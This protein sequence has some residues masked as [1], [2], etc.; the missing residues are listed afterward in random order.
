[1]LGGAGIG[2]ALAALAL[3]AGQRDLKRVLAYSTV[4][5][6]G[7][8][9]LGLGLGM[10]G[11]AS[12]APAIA[13][14]GFGAALLH[15]WN[16]ALMK[17]LAFLA[18]GAVVHG[19]GTRDL[20]RMGGLLR[21]MPWSGGALLVAA[22]AL[23]A[24]P[25]LNG[26]V[27]EWLLLL[28]LAQG[29]GAAHPGVALVAF[30]AL[31]ALAGVAGLAAVVFTRAVGVGLLGTPRSE[32][33][34]RAH[35]AGPL[36]LAPL[37]ALAAGCVAVAL[38]PGAIL[39]A[40]VPAVA[41]VERVP[42]EAVTGAL[43]PVAAALGGP[44]RAGVGALIVLAAALALGSRRALAGREVRSAATWGCGFPGAGPRVQYTAASYA[45]LVLSSGVPR[46][47]RPRARVEAPVGPFPPD[48][49][50]TLDGADPARTR[51]FEPAFRAIGDRFYRLRRFQ[52]S[53]LNLQLLYTV[54]AILALSALLLVHRAP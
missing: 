7:L 41:Q 33:A 10:V 51:L 39:G 16:H 50:V 31:G 12:G 47:V 40:L 17:G 23:A 38:A 34:A 15:V 26:F 28:G 5:N 54:I 19:A 49:R 25:P 36:L 3:A 11:A 4:E 20:E 14:L 35:E 13:A 22:G 9:A 27:S 37:A 21:R 8:V 53:R 18:A 24:L 44:M 32:E 30:L 46:P 45:Q 2:G 42:A 43:A 48:A 52:Q 6:V 1:V 29:G